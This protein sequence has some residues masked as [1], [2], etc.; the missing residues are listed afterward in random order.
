VFRKAEAMVE[1]FRAKAEALADET[2]PAELRELL[3]YLVD[4]VLERPAEPSIAETHPVLPLV[5]LTR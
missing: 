3:Y 5:Q 4:A 1:K 2:E